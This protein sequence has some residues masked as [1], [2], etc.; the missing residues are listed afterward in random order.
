MG[1]FHDLVKLAG[2][3]WR[4]LS[5]VGG[6]IGS[7]LAGLW[8]FILSVHNLLDHLISSVVRGLFAGLIAVGASLVANLSWVADALRRVASWIWG[9]EVLPVKVMLL[10]LIAALRAWTARQLAIQRGEYWG[11]FHI[12]EAYTRKLVTAETAARIKDVNAARAYALHLVTALHA[13]IEKEAAD[14]Y[15]SG[16]R[17]RGHVITR[18]IDDLAVRNPV[19][20]ALAG[21]LV[22]LIVDLAAIDNP[23]ARVAAIF[24]LR[25]VINHLGIDRVAGQLAGALLGTLAGRGQAK[26]LHAVISDIGD[27]L[28]VLEDAQAS[29]MEHGGPEIFQAGGQWKRLDGVLT[30]ATLLAFF[31][32]A[33][34]DP[35]RWAREVSAT[36]G[37]AVNGTIIAT[38]H[39]IKGR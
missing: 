21:R 5:G 28:T 17:A 13:A 7:A 18:I 4:L 16:R 3:A 20:R 11:L 8:H 31:A 9:F 1:F 25:Q 33:V 2:D 6:D 37:A 23:V 12:G 27:R 19:L 14:G 22:T 39:L 29:F 34:A 38:A 36:A 30:D 24:L 32:L 26:D 15:N 35:A 10:G